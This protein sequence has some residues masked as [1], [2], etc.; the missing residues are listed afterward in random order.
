VGKLEALLETE[1]GETPPG[2]LILDLHMVIN[3]DTTCQDT[4]ETLRR[5]LQKRGGALLLC[6]ANE[7]PLSLM[8]RSGFLARLGEENLLPDLIAAVGRARQLLERPPL[9]A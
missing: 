2:V 8:R 6:D 9:A 7:Q 5:S 3:L 4:L 1:Q